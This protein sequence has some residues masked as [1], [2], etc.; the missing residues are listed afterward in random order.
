MKKPL[1]I[2]EN[3]KHS[4]EN[5]YIFKNNQMMPINAYEVI[6][7][8]IN[9]DIYDADKLYR[10]YNYDFIKELRL[11]T[12]VWVMSFDEAK[13][14]AYKG[15]TISCGAL[16]FKSIADCIQYCKDNNLTAAKDDRIIQA[17]ILDC[18]K[19]IKKT[20]YKKT[21]KITFHKID[22]S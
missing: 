5:Y 10:Y 17:H 8:Y 14:G 3:L 12:G 15:F 20:A 6:Q 9:C 11:Y 2:I 18:L 19:G 1:K 21:W 16:Q 22:L 4:K 13:V 7:E